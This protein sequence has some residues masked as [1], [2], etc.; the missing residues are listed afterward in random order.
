VGAG[1]FVGKTDGLAPPSRERASECSAGLTGARA[2]LRERRR[3]RGLDLFGGLDRRT[4]WSCV[5]AAHGCEC[6]D[7]ELLS[8][9]ISPR[10]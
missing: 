9:S 8:P 5:G 10:R 7:G 6:E 1:V 3:S 2:A 4:V